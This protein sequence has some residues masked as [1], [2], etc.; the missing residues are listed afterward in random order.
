M[1]S[2]GGWAGSDQP[3]PRC[4][5]LPLI[6]S[7]AG[8]D[9]EGPPWIRVG[10]LDDIPRLG[11]RVVRFRAEDIAV[12]RTAD[13]RVFAMYDKCPHKQGKLSQGIVHGTSVTCPLHNWVIGLEDG[14]ARD[15]D[16]GCVR[17]VPAKLEGLDIML[18]LA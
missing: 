2:E 3:N 4:H 11:S 5:G 8:H 7:G 15:P 16:E 13:D 12:F 9:D 6:R 1:D 14:L 17:T 10:T 18:A